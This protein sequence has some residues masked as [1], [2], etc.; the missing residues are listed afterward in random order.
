[1]QVEAIEELLSQRFLPD[2]CG[3]AVG[4]VHSG[5]VI[6]RAGYGLASRE[7]TVPAQPD[8]VFALASLTKPFTA[9][10]VLR[11]VAEGR[12]DLERPVTAYLPDYPTTG[13]GVTIAHL[14]THTAGIPN[15]VTAEPDFWQRTAGFDLTRDEV[16]AL[17]DRKPLEFAPGTR[18][19]YSNSGYCLLGMIIE[20]V[21]G[22]SYGD[23]VTT[24]ILTP[25][26]MRGAR[27]ND[28]IQVIPRLAGGYRRDGAGTFRLPP[29]VSAALLYAAG[30]L[31][32]SVD[33]LI[34]WDQV[35][36]ERTLLPPEL[37]ERMWSPVHLADGHEE[38][39][40]F[41]WGLSTYR[42][43]RVVH[44]AGGIPGYSSFYGRFLEDDLAVIVLTNLGLFD[45][46]GLAKQLADAV[47]K[48]P[49]TA[50]GPVELLETDRTRMVGHYRNAVGEELE[51]VPSG[52]SLAVKGQIT[53]ELVPAGTGVFVAADNPDITV[54]FEDDGPAGYSRVKVIVP[55]Y[56]FVVY[57]SDEATEEV[58]EDENRQ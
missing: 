43:C 38:G 55:F 13:N 17:F 18:Y 44:H 28:G 34:A 2:G 49:E 32:A 57:R 46:G 36:R 42:G 52:N 41:G 25:A 33:D 20:A 5:T 19:S 27:Y 21:T 37:H 10:A 40:G 24:Q 11:L 45:A 39:Y 30:G 22:T 54:R 31:A 26:G 56:W 9:L 4:V 8:T 48:L 14:L 29:H 35:L 47:L 50:H 23:F 58:K 51:V 15:F 6:H 16:R 3:L 12:L 1:M 53:R 7:W